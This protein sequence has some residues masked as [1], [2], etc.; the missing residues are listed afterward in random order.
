MEMAIELKRIRLQDMHQMGLVCGS[1]L[2]QQII[3]SGMNTNTR[4]STS[5]KFEEVKKNFRKKIKA[6][7]VY[8]VPF[9]A[10]IH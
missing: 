2:L 3:N 8:I 4:F 7:S 5:H 1:G 9:T 10:N 6:I